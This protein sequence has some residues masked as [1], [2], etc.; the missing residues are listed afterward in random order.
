MNMQVDEN[1][2]VIVRSIIDLA[3][4]LGLHTTAE[5]VED[6]NSMVTL[7]AYGCDTVQGF[8]V[9][10]PAPVEAID[11]WLATQP[12]DRMPV[13]QRVRERHVVGAAAS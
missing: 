11:E 10:K 6:A 1:D 13:L 4:N 9:M 5:G 3:K 7:R 2:A 8:F 12:V